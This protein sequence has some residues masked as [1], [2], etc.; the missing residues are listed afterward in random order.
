MAGLSRPDL[1]VLALLPVVFSL[2]RFYLR[3]QLRRLSTVPPNE[4]RVLILGASGGVGQTIAHLYAERGAQVCIVG[5]RKEKVD[6]VVQECIER[7]REKRKIIGISADFAEVGDMVKLR[8]TLEREWNGVD[9][10]II[11]AG[12]SA[13]QPLMAVAALEAQPGGAEFIP[14]Q[15]SQNDIQKAVDIAALATRGNFVGPLVSALTFVPLLLKSSASPSILL[16]SSLAALIP[17]PTRSLYAATKSASLL[18]FQALAIEHPSI[19]FSFV[20]PSTIEGDFRASAVDAG[21]LREKDPNKAG[22]PR[23]E[24]A[25]RCIDAVDKGERNVFMPGFTRFGNLLYWLYPTF[26]EWRAKIKYNY[27]V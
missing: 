7:S 19:A 12:V 20:M 27:S 17:A 16:L 9:T 5:R 25:K 21:P 22:L 10:I 15:A 18:L 13:L 1:Y 8:E 11:P 24:V 23:K 3:S 14:S 4:E 26:V 2:R 6:Q